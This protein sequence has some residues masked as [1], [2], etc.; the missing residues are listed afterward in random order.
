M[1]AFSTVS[2]SVDD[3]AERL[4]AYLEENAERLVE[5]W[6]DWVEERVASRA[7]RA[8]S[9][10]SIRNHITPVLRAIATYVRTPGSATHREMLGHLEMHANLRRELGY[11]LGELL[12]EF[13]GLAH[14]V[15]GELRRVL[16]GEDHGPAVVV[17]AYDRVVTGLR[18][19]GFVTVGMYRD[20]ELDFQRRIAQRLD[21]FSRTIAHE[22]RSPLQT[23]SLAVEMLG[24]DRVGAD[25][26]K[27]EKHLATIAKAVGRAN[28]LLDDIRQLALVES[29]QA[30]RIGRVRLLL[31]Q[32]TGELQAAAR[33][34]KVDLEIDARVPD[35]C[36]DVLTFQL[37]LV[38]VIGNAIKYSDAEK[39]ERWIRVAVSV[40]PGDDEIEHLRVTVTDN[41]LGIAKAYVGRVFQ[42][43]IRAH[44]EVAEGTGLGLAI[45]RQLVQESGGHI[46]LESREGAGTTVTFRLPSFPGDVS[47]MTSGEHSALIVD[48]AARDELRS[49]GD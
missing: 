39:D 46:T 34:R 5:R 16:E 15:S 47:S 30:Q 43:H 20:S 4:A 45:T 17:E 26:A 49:E 25:A 6:I 9:R 2:N 32:I 10:D 37:A 40:T 11:D 28:D 42:R 13:D 23:V 35:V 38:N 8:L 31:E 29:G 3:V 27:R 21:E 44:P 18:A 24:D 22:M 7:V 14:L 36:V 48:R 41:G 1:L 33:E 19:I 12:A